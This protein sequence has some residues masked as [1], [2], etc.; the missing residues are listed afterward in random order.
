METNLPTNHEVKTDYEVPVLVQA[1]RSNRRGSILRRE[2]LEGLKLRNAKHLPHRGTS[3]LQEKEENLQDSRG[4][5][6]NTRTV[7]RGQDSS[8]N[9]DERKQIRWRRSRARRPPIAPSREEPKD[10]HQKPPFMI[11]STPI[12]EGKRSSERKRSVG[13]WD[14][15]QRLEGRKDKMASLRQKSSSKMKELEVEAV[16][17][18]E[19]AF[20]KLYVPPFGPLDDPPGVIYL[21]GDLKQKT[22]D[23]R[24][25]ES[26]G[27][28]VQA[29]RKELFDLGTKRRSLVE[30]ISAQERRVNRGFP[31]DL[32]AEGVHERKARDFDAEKEKVEAKLNL[33]LDH[34][35]RLLEVLRTSQA[36]DDKK[37]AVSSILRS[38]GEA[39]Q[40]GTTAGRI[41]DARAEKSRRSSL[42]DTKDLVR[43]LMARESTLPRVGNTFTPDW[44]R[45]HSWDPTTGIEEINREFNSNIQTTKEEAEL[46]LL[47]EGWREVIDTVF[48]K[49]KERK[50]GHVVGS[51]A[52]G[53]EDHKDA[54][55]LGFVSTATPREHL[56]FLIEAMDPS[57]ADDLS[58]VIKSILLHYTGP[59]ADE[60]D[61]LLGGRIAS[62]EAQVV[63]YMSLEALDS[64]HVSRVPSILM[65]QWLLARASHLRSLLLRGGVL[66]RA[67]RRLESAEVG[68]GFGPRQ[69]A[70]QH[71]ALSL[72]VGV[73][74]S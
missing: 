1:P 61:L 74:F 65:L 3:E 5:E 66:R 46:K 43:E 16:M 14:L 25:L 31:R 10:S 67:F 23:V 71:S 59:A 44:S 17:R 36:A 56:E 72:V 21:D 6:D 52:K 63:V 48:P 37:V 32:A 11:D 69:R 53:D 51:T 24:V 39:W 45:R 50:S 20:S 64:V 33:L 62:K 68:P 54:S 42:E 30:N 7:R 18:M 47:N 35:R 55:I 60:L 41:R 22:I 38:E 2:A 26:V 9:N 34:R 70:M 27:E 58:T 73:L 19:K 12:V 40:E 8:S 29:T 49:A 15:K 28:G 4:D 13:E 57:R